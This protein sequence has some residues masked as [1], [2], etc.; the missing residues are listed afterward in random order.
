MKRNQTDKITSFVLKVSSST[1]Q[2]LL[3]Q[4][5]GKDTDADHE[6]DEY[7]NGDPLNFHGISL[8]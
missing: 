7:C 4:G 6:Y 5:L 1:P 3:V 2:F 8:F